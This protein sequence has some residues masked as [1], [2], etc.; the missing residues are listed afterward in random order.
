MLERVEGGLDEAWVQAA[1]IAE[2][3]ILRSLGRVGIGLPELK[4]AMELNPGFQFLPL[5]LPQLE[6]FAE[7]G[8][9]QDPFDRLIVSA[10]RAIHARLITRDRGLASARFVETIWA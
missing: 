9:I 10:A 8:A 5:D 1:V 4:R 6:E 2:I 7:L 3:V